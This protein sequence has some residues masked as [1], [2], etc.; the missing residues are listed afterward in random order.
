M[1]TDRKR[2]PGPLKVERAYDEL[3]RMI[4][5]HELPP[6]ATIDERELMDQLE[7]GRTPL[8]EAMLRLAHERLIVRSPRRGAWVSQLSLTD[9]LQLNEARQLVEPPIAR[10]AAEHITPATAEQLRS[11]LQRTEQEVAQRDF[12]TLA[13]VDLEYHLLLG[14]LAANDYLTNFSMEINTSLLR[15]W[16][17]SFRLDDSA[18]VW[19]ESHSEL[20]ECIARGDV[21][22][23]AAE[24]QAHID[25]YRKRMRR[26]MG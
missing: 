11:I 8:R 25:S 22:A 2:F 15:Y 19:Y 6:G 5:T 23:A 24:A 16:H 1:A 4:I 17:L 10:L 20:V 7:I 12:A 9:I 3:R 13:V 18:Q 26:F 21:D 14:K